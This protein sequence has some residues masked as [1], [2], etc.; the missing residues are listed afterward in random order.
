M[1][2]EERYEEKLNNNALNIMHK[3][4]SYI[5]HSQVQKCLNYFSFEKLPSN[6]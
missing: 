3:N 5:M 1:K 4:T 2:R 6:M